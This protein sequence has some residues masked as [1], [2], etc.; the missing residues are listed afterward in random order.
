MPST[1]TVYYPFH[2]LHN[3]CLEVVAWPRQ[4]TQAITV[5]HPDGNTLKV[6]RWMLQPDAAR[7]RLS[8]SSRSNS[9]LA[10]SAEG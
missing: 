5:R 4:V 6:P 9:S 3:R 7:F 10:G 2:P 1:V 8:G